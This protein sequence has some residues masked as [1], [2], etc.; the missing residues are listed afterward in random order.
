MD[1]G[2]P[3]RKVNIPVPVEAPAFPQYV[4]MTPIE[5]PERETVPVKR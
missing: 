1:L 5:M 3:V 4:P 2:K